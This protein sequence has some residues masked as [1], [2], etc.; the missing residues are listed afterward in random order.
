M[1]VKD[2]F[3]KILAF[4]SFVGVFFIGL[5]F[6]KSLFDNGKRAGDDSDRKRKHEE[7]YREAIQSADSI[8]DIIKRVKARG[9]E[10]ESEG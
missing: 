6:G 5:L 9:G 7:D 4:L 1:N 2:V 10:G 3:K 8:R